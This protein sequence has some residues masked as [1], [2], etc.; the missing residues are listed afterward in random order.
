M[1]SYTLK[2][3]KNLNTGKRVPMVRDSNCQGKELQ[4]FW[5]LVGCTEHGEGALRNRACTEHMR[6]NKLRA[7]GKY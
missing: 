2:G 3:K 1:T 6:K 4:Q 7:G 5:N